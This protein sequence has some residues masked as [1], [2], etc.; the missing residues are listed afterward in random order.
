[1]KYF[2]SD[3]H[4]NHSEILYIDERPFQSIFD[5]K[6]TL[7][8][9]INSIVKEDD[10]LYVI[11]DVAFRN[12]NER[13]DTIGK[14]LE[15][16]KVKR[17]ILI[18]GNHDRLDWREYID[19][20]FESVHSSLEIDDYVLNHDPAIAVIDKKKKFLCGHVHKQYLKLNNI[21]NV[22]CCC[23]NYKPVPMTVI[24]GYFEREGM[25]GMVNVK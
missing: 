6:M 23:W 12:C 22:G 13:N 5:M 1:M 3:W 19:L 11:G 15:S 10:I 2:T 20:G 25:E 16:M 7:L 18:V 14:F 4:I 24:D 9:N 21:L 17:K 8:N